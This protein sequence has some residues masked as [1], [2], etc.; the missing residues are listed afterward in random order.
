MLSVMPRSHDP[1]GEKA[2]AWD[3][4]PIWTFWRTADPRPKSGIEISHRPAISNSEWLDDL[5]RKTVAVSG[6][7]KKDGTGGAFRSLHPGQFSNV[8]AT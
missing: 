8:R 7:G 6:K 5:R 3:P 4:Q 1:R 2:K